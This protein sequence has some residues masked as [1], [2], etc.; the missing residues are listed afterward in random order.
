MDAAVYSEI[1]DSLNQ[2]AEIRNSRLAGGTPFNIL[3]AAVK[4]RLRETTHSRILY[5]LL[6]YDDR[7]LNSFLEKFFPGLFAQEKEWNLSVEN[8]KI[9]ILIEGERNAIIIEN[10]VNDA[11]EQPNQIDRYVEIYLNKAK[12]VYVIYLTRGHAYC[13]SPYSWSKTVG[14]CTLKAVCYRRD[15][16]GWIRE[17]ME[18]HDP[19]RLMHHALSQYS[20]YLEIMFGEK[21]EAMNK[22]IREKISALL[23]TR[24]GQG[25]IDSI[26][27]LDELLK[28]L[29]FLT[30]ECNE[31][32]YNLIWENIRHYVERRLE[33]LK[34]GKLQ[35]MQ[36]KEWDLPDFGIPFK[37]KGLDYQFYAV[38]SY[39]RGRYIGVIN[40]EQKERPEDKLSEKF[41]ALLENASLGTHYS[42]AR[43][44]I[45]FKCADDEQLKTDYIKL[46]Q[47]LKND[48]ESQNH[49]V[50]LDS[51]E[52]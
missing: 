10:K 1:S 41:S 18:L 32:R 45:W 43:Y 17:L 26:S 19:E 44:P 22:Q 6:D 50:L 20:D 3:D 14:E 25:S 46:V 16:R 31:L 40:I 28:E 9:D 38:I 29:E 52:D 51:V 33:E 5:R 42:T 7:I 35:N 37:L 8:N 4:T 21:Q 23:A 24:Q 49:S 2:I 36:D 30:N 39:L 12:E 27:H 13:P 48:S 47:A 34:L 11:V 15:I